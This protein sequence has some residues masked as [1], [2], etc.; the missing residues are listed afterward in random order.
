MKD[1]AFKT[2]IVRYMGHKGEVTLQIESLISSCL[3][4]FQNVCEPRSVIMPFPCAV[5]ESGVKTDSLTIES[6]FLASHIK[7]C[8]Q[9][10]LLAATLGAEVD[11]LLNQRMKVNSAQALC[12]QAC[13]A[14]KIEEYCGEIEKEI[15]TNNNKCCLLPRFSPGYGDFKIEHQTDILRMLD[16]H[17]KIGLGETK[18][19][20]LTPLKSVTA[21]IGAACSEDSQ[22]GF[23]NKCASCGKKNCLYAKREAALV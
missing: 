3:E 21:V 4:K 18:T 7:G 22:S 13:A 11:R 19:H 12:L 14:A 16:A 15:S 23:T 1:M 2:E 9:I 6:R 20:M 8:S 17:K 5:T 10:F